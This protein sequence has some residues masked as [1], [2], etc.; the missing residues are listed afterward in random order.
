MENN[1]RKEKLKYLKQ[2]VGDIFICDAWKMGCPVRLELITPQCRIYITDIISG[3]PRI[4]SEDYL[5]CTWRLR[6]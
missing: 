1:K 3:E 6:Y 5:D 2:H 4:L